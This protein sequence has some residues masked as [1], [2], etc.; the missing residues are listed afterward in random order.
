MSYHFILASGNPHKGEEFSRLFDKNI[1]T[2]SSAPEK[3]EVEENGTSFRQNALIKAEAYNHKYKT[4]VL[5][6]DSGLTVPS[7]PDELGIHSARFGGPGL[8]DKDR[9]MLLLNKI[10][11][12]TGIDRSAYFVC[13]LCFYFSKKEIFFF[14][15]RIEGHIGNKYYGTYGFGFDPVFVPHLPLLEKEKTLAELP[16]WKK[17]YS[18]RAK[19]CH[20]A[21]V[22]F[23]R[24]FGLNKND[25]TAFKRKCILLLSNMSER[26]AAW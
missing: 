10:Q 5:S 18:H 23:S 8:S 21:E 24:T 14:E 4:P 3:I 1:I 6:D 9:A 12:K 7:L 20:L 16:F 13:L 19:A 25:E 22:F 17:K 26:G 11:D 15:G 2:L